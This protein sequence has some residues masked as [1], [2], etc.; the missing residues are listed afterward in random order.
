MFM[1]GASCFG[2]LRPPFRP[3]STAR[4]RLY[5]KLPG[6]IEP[7]FRPARLALARSLAK[8]PGFV[9]AIISPS[10][11]LIAGLSIAVLAGV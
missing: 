9:F 3:A 4:F 11:V 1:S 10:L 5:L 7:P 8:L 6:L 2:Y